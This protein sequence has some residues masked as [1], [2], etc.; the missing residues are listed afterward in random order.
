MKRS[1]QLQARIQYAKRFNGWTPNSGLLQTSLYVSPLCNVRQSPLLS[2]AVAYTKAREKREILEAREQAS[3]HF[4]Y[5]LSGRLWPSPRPQAGNQ[6]RF[7]QA[8]LTLP[9]ATYS[10]K[11]LR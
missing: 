10:K 1:E 6:E 3:D 5:K 2:C 9:V 4:A 7:E 11:A 8:A